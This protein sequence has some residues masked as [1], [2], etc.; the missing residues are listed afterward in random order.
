MNACR[1]FSN[2][3]RRLSRWY[4]EPDYGDRVLTLFSRNKSCTL[5]R[6]NDGNLTASGNFIDTFHEVFIELIMNNKGFVTASSGNLSRATGQVCAESIELIVK[7][8]LNITKL[9]KKEIG[10]L[11]GGPQGCDHLVDLVNELSRAVATVIGG[12]YNLKL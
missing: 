5:C 9:S 11:V 2:L 7:I 3:E 10:E 1:Y 6:Q 4:D 12:K 8:D